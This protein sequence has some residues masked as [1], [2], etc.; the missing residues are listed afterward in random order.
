MVDMMKRFVIFIF[1]FIAVLNVSA[2]SKQ[3]VVDSLKFE[4][5]KKQLTTF[6]SVVNTAGLDSIFNGKPVTILA[7]DEQAFAK[8][9][10]GILDSLLKPANKTALVN[11]LNDHVIPGKLSSKDVARLIHENNG[12]TVFTTLLGIKLTAKINAN[13]NIVFTD[14]S[15][16]ECIVKQFD[17]ADGNTVIFVVSSVILPKK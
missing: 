12:Q 16:N 10:A 15:G 6:F 5:A 9:P 7:P 8:L 11:L 13:R 3:T 14:E 2:Q 4:S 1:L 17:I